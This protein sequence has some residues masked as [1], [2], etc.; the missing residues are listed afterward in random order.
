MKA[1]VLHTVGKPLELK[2]Q[3]VPEPDNTQ[4]LLKVHSC[5]ICRTDLHI[6]DGELENPNLP[7]IWD[8]KL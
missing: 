8:T 5:G 2:E 6:I 7:L 4:L 3:P 1:M